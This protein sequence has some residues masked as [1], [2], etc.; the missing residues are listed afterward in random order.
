MPSIR[1]DTLLEAK[2][3]GL[4]LELVGGQAGLSR[5]ITGPR[6]QKPGLALTGYTSYLHP[7]RLQVLGLTEISYLRSIT[8]E[9]RG[10]GL[11][12][13]CML[14]P[15]AVV[16]TRGL[17]VPEELIKGAELHAV[18]VFSTPLMSSVFINRVTKYLEERLAPTTSVHGVL[19]DVLG[20]GILLLGKSGIGKSEAALDLVLRGHRL[21]A[22]DI[23]EIRKRPP[24]MIYGSGSDIIK[25]HMEI[26]GLGIINI[27]DLFGIS[28]VRDAKKIE[29]VVEL[30][31]WNED[32][33]Y[34]RLGVEEL[35]HS[36]L[37]VAVP[38]LRVP[39]RPGRNISSII[40]VAARNLLL[41]FQGKHS[42][43][44]F[45]ERLNRALV[46]ARAD[47]QQPSM[48]LDEVE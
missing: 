15:S 36:I 1:V 2:D 16:V 11:E 48:K 18:P 13:L 28:A 22:D 45:Q 43:K 5:R 27:K 25:H 26:R 38:M 41:K 6:I 19:I 33:E 7:E 39:I 17:E 8:P 42:A 21:V 24:D 37:D 47:E 14:Q 46:D 31:E 40:E 30:V 12:T 34:D 4:A 20:V 3:A 23:V 32:E 10:R 35:R 29:L 44:E 9:Q